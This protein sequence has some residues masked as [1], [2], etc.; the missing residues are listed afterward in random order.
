MSTQIAARPQRIPRVIPHSALRIPNFFPNSEF[1][2]PN[3]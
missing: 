1:R 3:F 2:L